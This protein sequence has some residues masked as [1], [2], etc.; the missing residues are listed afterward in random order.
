MT[1]A[2]LIKELEK[3]PQ[4][5]PVALNGERDFTAEGVFYNDVFDCVMIID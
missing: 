3:M 2:E 4:D 5:K 1:V